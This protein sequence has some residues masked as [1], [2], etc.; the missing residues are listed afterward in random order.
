MFSYHVARKAIPY[1]DSSGSIVTPS[2]ASGL[3]LEM[4]VFDA[5]ER[6]TNMQCLAVDRAS[7]FSPVKNA[8]GSDSPATARQALALYHYKLLEQAGA[9]I[10]NKEKLTNSHQDSQSRE[11]IEE[12]EEKEKGKRRHVVGS[13]TWHQQYLQMILTVV[14]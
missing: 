11:G 3:K 10:Q 13:M 12:E 4:F 1:V 6:S 5:F 7:E 8:A 9:T 2:Q 14:Y